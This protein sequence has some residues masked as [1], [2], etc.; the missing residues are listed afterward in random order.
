MRGVLSGAVGILFFAWLVDYIDRLVIT[1]ALPD[2]GRTFHIGP[3]A[4]G[5]ILS[6]FF[7]MYALFQ[8]PGGFL[9]DRL[10]ARKTMTLA[11]AAWSLF[12]GLTALASSY[13]LLIVV[14]GLFGVSEGIFPA[15]SMKAICE[16]VP[17][18]KR[19]AANGAM[20][21][22]NPLGTALA[23]LFA[24]PALALVGWRGAF[25]WVMLLGLLMAFVVYRFLSH[26]HPGAKKETITGG[27]VGKRSSTV[28]KTGMMW[29]F[30]IMFF[31]FDIVAWGLVAWGP[32]YLITVR[33]VHVLT[34]GFLTSIPWFAATVGTFLGGYL[35]DRY[36][37]DRHRW[38]I[39]P[40]MV[41]TGVTI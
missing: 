6:A 23:P 27:G 13:F 36:F 1:L 28:L 8:I 31:G 33:H 29:R 25:Y 24:A 38:I 34:T 15:A 39:V 11:L 17:A 40:A 16:R 30:A 10:G 35:F 7:L 5:F 14:R 19:M 20:L 12:T 41:L 9:A 22:S 32:S 37:A 18:E 3:V 4:Q 2:I 26:D 21:A